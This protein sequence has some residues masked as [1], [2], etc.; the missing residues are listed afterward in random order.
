MFKTPKKKPEA[1]PA[2]HTLLGKGML[3]KGEIHCGKDSL[4]VEGTIEGTIHSDGEVVVAPTGLVNGIIHARHLIVTGRV[5]GVFRIEE[6]LE[7]HGTGCVEGEVEIGSL[8]VDEGGILQGVCTRR[9]HERQVMTGSQGLTVP[10]AP[11]STEEAE[12]PAQPSEPQDLGSR[13]RKAH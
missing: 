2:I 12:A 4:R 5:E 9:G 3:W 1:A 6:C 13:K 7:I 11:A 10:K 8:V